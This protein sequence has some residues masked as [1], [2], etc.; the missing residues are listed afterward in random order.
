M[1]TKLTVLDFTTT[2]TY[3][4]PLNVTV[5]VINGLH[6]WSCPNTVVHPFIYILVP[7][8]YFIIFII[9]L[10]GNGMVM[11]IMCYLHLKSVTDVYI[12]NLALADFLFVAT[13]PLWAISM[14]F[15]YKW[16]FGSVMC[17]ICAVLAALNMYASIFFITCMSIDRYHGI[18]QTMKSLKTRR[19]GYAKKLSVFIWFLAFLASIPTII[20]RRNDYSELKK[21]FRCTMRYPENASAE[22]GAGMEL[23]KNTLG[24]IIPFLLQGV[25]YFLI[26]KNLHID[27]RNSIRKRRQSKA[28]RMVISVVLAFLL[29]WLPF[30]VITFIRVLMQLKVITDCR[31]I[32]NVQTALPI[33][34]SIAYANSC[35][36]PILYCF[37]GG[38]FKNFLL[39]V[40]R[41][42][43][44][45]ESY[46]ESSSRFLGQNGSTHT[47]LEDCF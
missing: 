28:L 8:F 7:S 47:E 17:I 46:N 18:V 45:K 24:F 12:F 37:V 44:S 23:M 31:T 15:H 39:K 38:R 10:V 13:L 29:C 36:N 6:H 5:P 43:N 35:I 16:L 27:T 20:F 42:R 1:G 40:F 32:G 30:Q 19:V 2:S 41:R 22:W 25:C 14:W 34:I 21:T 3:G 33:T 11:A 26:Y 9:G 4:S